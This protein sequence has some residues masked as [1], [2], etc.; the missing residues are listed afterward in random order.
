MKAV[1]TTEARRR[2]W[3]CD[4]DR[5]NPLSALTPGFLR[6][7]IF[8]FGGV[9]PQNVPDVPGEEEPPE[10]EVEEEPPAGN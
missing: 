9:T 2:S 7:I 8:G 6:G 10:E 5:A 1:I 3:S 4:D